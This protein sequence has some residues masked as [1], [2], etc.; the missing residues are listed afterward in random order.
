MADSLFS[1][2]ASTG[3]SEGKYRSSLID[4]AS[5]D[6]T[7]QLSQR[8][9]DVKQD[10]FNKT[11]G[12]IA[13]TLSLASTAT[14]LY[15]EKASQVKILEDEY[16][17]MDL[18][19][20]EGQTDTL[21]EK[22]RRGIKIGFGIGDYKFGDETIAAKDFGIRSQKIEYQNMFSE[23]MENLK[24]LDLDTS[25]ETTENLNTIN[26]TIDAPQDTIDWTT[27]GDDATKRI[28]QYL[29]VD[30]DGKWGKKTQAAYNALS[31]EDKDWVEVLIGEEWTD[32]AG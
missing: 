25:I 23:A 31:D 16:G 15:E 1:I 3:R 17:E 11:V 20:K 27:I 21:F 18:G 7:R 13:D 29:G 30:V 5:K 22:A 12:T 4:I 19:L 32:P 14:G 9:S 26:Q 6:T 28:Q 10:Q 8:L 24:K 2:G